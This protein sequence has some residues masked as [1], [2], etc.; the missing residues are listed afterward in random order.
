MEN[1]YQSL[2][3]NILNNQ[4][5]AVA[6]VIR[7]EYLG[8]KLLVTPDG[9]Q[10]GDLGSERLNQRALEVARTALASQKPQRVEIETTTEPVELFVDVFSPKPRMII[11]GAVHI[12]IPLVTLAKT[13]GFY[14]IVVDPRKAF[15]SDERFSHSDQ[16]ISEW[17]Q[18]AMQR[19]SI[20]EA[21]CIVTLTHDEKIDN[22]ALAYA[23]GSKARYIGA[24]GSKKTHALRVEALKEEGVSEE[25]IA[26]IH[27]PIGLNIGAEGPY[28]IAV[29]IIAEIV[30]ERHKVTA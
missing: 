28:E 19:L 16:L 5:T 23:L 8:K 26:R 14:T 3:N 12:A 17:P 18:D 29:S 11:I 25:A 15:A 2:R 21:T 22:P 7:G 13:V 27:G 6:T 1:I 9:T 20:D 10:I 24:L 4:L 30:A